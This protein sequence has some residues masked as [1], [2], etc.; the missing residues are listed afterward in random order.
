LNSVYKIELSSEGC[1]FFDDLGND[2]LNLFY[3]YSYC[4]EDLLGTQLM[5]PSSPSLQRW[6]N[7]N[8][9]TIFLFVALSFVC[10]SI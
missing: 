7:G 5:P 4:F 10:Y 9:A 2:A 6:E 3:W 1:D 8:F